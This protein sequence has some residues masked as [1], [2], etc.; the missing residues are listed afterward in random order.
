MVIGVQVHLV[1]LPYPQLL[2]SGLVDDFITAF[3]GQE[4][5]EMRLKLGA[6]H[7]ELRRAECLEREC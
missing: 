2:Y 1:T 6:E 5:R 3:L 7:G 4:K